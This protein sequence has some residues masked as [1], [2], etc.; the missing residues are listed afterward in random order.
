M[1]KYLF[2]ITLLSIVFACSSE[3]GSSSSGDNYNRTAL[4]T[5]WANNIIV[6]SYENLQDKVVILNSAIAT[7]NTTP[8]QTNLD[9]LRSAWLESYKAYQ[10]VGFFNI[11][12][13]E[14]INFFSKT[15]IYPTNTAGID[16]NIASGSYNFQLLSQ[17]SRQGFPALDYMINGLASSDNNIIEFYT[18]NSNALNYKQYLTDLIAELSSDVNSILN[19]WNGSYK[20][21]FIASNGNSVSSSTNRM[22]NNFVKYYEKDI[23][24]GKVGIPAGVFSSGTTFPEKGEAFYK[25]DV[26]K[27][28][29][30][31]AVKAA[32]DFFNGKHYLSS[33]EGESLKSYLNFLNTVRNGVSLS[34]T[35]NNQFTT[36]NSTNALLNDSFETQ[37]LSN[38][39]AMLNSYDALQQ[40]VVYFKL[41][42][43]QAFNITV[44]YVDA[45]GD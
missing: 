24:A 2:L 7:F 19:D 4:L 25:N 30:N 34:T 15:N 9:V 44:D 41:D 42:M 17:Y 20:N 45:D 11:G 6:P 31:E 10:Y 35:I 1:K 37:I 21:T 5:N 14:E 40:N 12:K 39:N 38:N 28:L 43:M 27:I 22:V 23:R 16:T 29:L 18:T 13:A 8:N 36:I 26:S 33:T 32:Q 3:D